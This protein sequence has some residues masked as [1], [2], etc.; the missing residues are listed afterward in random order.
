[1]RIARY[2]FLAKEE[3]VIASALAS[4]IDWK[5][6]SPRAPHFGGLWEAAVK[7]MKRHLLTVSR[8]LMLTYEEYYTLLVEVEAVL[9]SRP[10]TP[11]SSN[12]KDLSALTSSHFLIGDSQIKPAQKSYLDVPDNRLSRWQHLQKVRQHFW[13][14]WN[15]EYLQ[16]LQARSKWF[17]GKENVEL[18]TMVLVQDGNL[19]PLQWMMG[20]VNETFPGKDGVVR[21]ATIKTSRGELKRPIKKLC[22]L[23]IEV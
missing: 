10:L 13:Q 12:P 22:P 16:T 19:P 1:M 5:F 17:S 18:D 21:V 6:N 23:P 7:A 9:N 11:I 8:G 2:E 20:R 15:K 4:Q 14:R 3:K